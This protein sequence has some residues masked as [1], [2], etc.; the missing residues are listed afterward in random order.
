VTRRLIALIAAAVLA[1][2]LMPIGVASASAAA[3]ANLASSAQKVFPSPSADVPFSISVQ[4][5][6]TGIIGSIGGRSINWV[7]VILP[8][9]RGFTLGGAAGSI[10]KTGWTVTETRTASSQSLTYH[11]GVLTS[12]STTTFDFP[13]RIARPAD[14]DREAPFQVLVSGDGGQ[15]TREATGTLTS[16][17][18]ILEVVSG[19]VSAPGGAAD[20]T[21]SAGQLVSYSMGIRNHAA[22]AVSVTPT[23]T[24]RD[25]DTVQTAA[26][27]ASVGGNGALGTF[28]SQV[29]LNP[30]IARDANHRF[31]VSAAKTTGGSVADT[32]QFLYGVQV[33]PVLRLDEGSFQP[34]FVQ[35]GTG[36]DY[37]YSANFTKLNTPTLLVT[38][39]TLSFA[40]T[41]AALDLPSGGAPFNGAAQELRSVRQVPQ[42]QDGDYKVSYAFQI[43]DGNGFSYTQTLTSDGNLITL[44]A[45]DPIVR[46][47]GV[48]L[49]NDADNQRQTR[50]KDNDLVTINGEARDRNIDPSG[51]TV[52]IRV[53][54]G[55][56]FTI[57]Q[58]NV[59]TT[60]VTGGFNWTATFRPTFGVQQGNFDVEA[61]LVD[62]AERS[63][64]ADLDELI[65]IDNIPPQL[66]LQGYVIDLRRIEVVFDENF[67]I[68]GGCN[69]LLY[70]VDGELLVSSVS[71][72]DG[73]TCVSGRAA[74]DGVAKN[75]RVLTLMRDRPRGDE[76]SVRYNPRNALGGNH[77]DR[78]KDA[79][80]HYSA[81]GVQDVISLVRPPIPTL[82]LVRRNNDTE[83]AVFDEGV[84]WTRFPNGDTV[85]RI[86][87]AGV[88]S[89]DVLES[90]D[91]NGNVLRRSAPA[92]GNSATL[93]VVVPIGTTDGTYARSIR[94]VSA[95]NIAG[96]GLPLSI[97]LDRAAPTLQSATAV[98]ENTVRVTFSEVVW[99]GT[100]FASDWRAYENDEGQRA[101][102]GVRSVTGNRTTRDLEVARQNFGPLNAAQYLFEALGTNTRYED[103]AGNLHATSSP[104]LAI[105]Q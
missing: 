43:L 61:T 55:E 66:G 91:Q 99:A 35:V 60:N 32:R 18:K 87:G 8:A 102:I 33:P 21:G 105:A 83:T 20:G 31:D 80:G 58:S 84:F 90:L 39:G 70:S 77:S 76:P 23:L 4:N 103:R 12:G 54:G 26:S 16:L 24:P 47:L 101:E 41:T 92:G 62:R 10:G 100:N 46:I 49:P 37:R 50:A 34:R 1:F 29:R 14:A 78:V 85:A 88:R 11:S 19:G 57:P 42:G 51:L 97:A 89:G 36:R 75:V 2:A 82:D 25:G 45:L 7:R 13:V 15:T 73:S 95:R 79:A 22:N 56:T 40:D 67:E 98:N 74:P 59:S 28:V 96:E 63:A 48:V 44:D 53:Q 52:R 94:L 3:T 72:A 6:E 104:I 38:S 69:P 30:N 68:L 93:S 65:G 71:Y 86:T 17:V 27:A 81:L 9:S 64:G 5:N